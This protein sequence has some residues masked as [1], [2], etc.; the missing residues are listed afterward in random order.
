M[1]LGGELRQAEI[2]EL[3]L[4]ARG[5][6]NVGGLEVAMNDAFLVRGIQRVG[7]LHT[8]LDDGLDCKNT[9]GDTFLERFTLE[10]LHHDERLPIV[11]PNFVNS[12]DV[13]M[14]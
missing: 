10:Q 11:F 14:V 5:H 8:N 3:G 12:A 13:G 4:A 7:D 2:Q 6:E 1:G 9:P